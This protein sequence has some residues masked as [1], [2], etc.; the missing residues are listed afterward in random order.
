MGWNPKARMGARESLDLNTPK[1]FSRN[2]FILRLGH[3]LEKTNKQ[4]K[5]LFLGVVSHVCKSPIPDKDK[6]HSLPV[7]QNKFK[8][9]LG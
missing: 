6:T 9:S 7:L 5:S 3:H 4:T 2:S 8:A 1:K